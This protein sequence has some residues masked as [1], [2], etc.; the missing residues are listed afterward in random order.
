[1]HV[2]TESEHLDDVRELLRDELETA[3]YPPRDVE[4]IEREQGGAELVAVLLSTAADPKELDELVARLE[5]KRHVENASW[6]LRHRISSSQRPE[7]RR[8]DAALG[9]GFVGRGDLQQH[10]FPARLGAE[11]QRERQ[12]RRGDRGRRRRTAPE[13]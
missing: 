1:M 3:H 9:G 12:A 10:V 6:N 5:S 4:V 7:T 13:T 8:R 11:H 2:T